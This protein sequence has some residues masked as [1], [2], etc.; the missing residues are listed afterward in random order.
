MHDK[1]GMGLRIAQKGVQAVLASIEQRKKE[2]EQPIELPPKPKLARGEVL[3]EIERENPS[4]WSQTWLGYKHRIEFD[5]LKR[6]P[7]MASRSLR[8]ACFING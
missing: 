7:L 1:T 5:E 2:E 6:R 4:N 3:S 8:S